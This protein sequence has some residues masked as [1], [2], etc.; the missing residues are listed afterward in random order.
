MGRIKMADKKRKDETKHSKLVKRYIHTKGFSELA[1]KSPEKKN[2]RFVRNRVL[3]VAAVI[4][5]IIP[6]IYFSFF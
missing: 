1:G 2:P 5:F 4:I 6:G 3:L